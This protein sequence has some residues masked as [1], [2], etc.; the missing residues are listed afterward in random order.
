VCPRVR[1]SRK[2]GDPEPAS[3]LRS[4]A[5]PAQSV[6]REFASF[7]RA[8]RYSGAQIRGMPSRVLECWNLLR[9][10]GLSSMTPTRVARA[11]IAGV[12]VSILTTLG[13]CGSDGAPD[14]PSFLCGQRCVPFDG[15]PP[16]EYVHDSGVIDAGGSPD[17]AKRNP[18]CGLSSSCNPDDVHAC[19]AELS[20]VSDAS[21]VDASARADHDG[22]DAGAPEMEAA[23][24]A[25]G[26]RLSN[27]EL[28]A[29]CALA[30]A[31]AVGAACMTAEDCSAGLACVG[32]A[33]GGQCLAYCCSGNDACKAGTYCVERPLTGLA[34][35]EPALV[36]VCAPADDCDLSQAYPC[37]LDVQANGSCTCT[38]PS[39]ACSVVRSDGTTSCVT[40]GTGKL[41]DACPCAWGYICS[42]STN[43]CLKMCSTLSSDGTC[44]G[45]KCQAANYLPRA[46]G[47]CVGE[48]TSSYH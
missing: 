23:T 29:A 30:G 24:F 48:S 10:S 47:V 43:S 33:S 15:S 37:P 1:Q 17:A 4:R 19:D 42:R 11:L 28:Q 5:A 18:L 12:I 8:W 41:G 46:L 6:S 22:N 16:D 21:S 35:R 40:P 27:G 36:P 34:G 25:C 32:D 7:A 20:A 13:A 3:P 39:T 31:R 14:H 26:V 44:G 2:L 9:H 38:D 45:G